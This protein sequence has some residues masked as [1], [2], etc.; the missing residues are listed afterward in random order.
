MNS[1]CF[2]KFDHS[3]NWYSASNDCLSRGGSLAVFTDIGYPS[4]NRQLAD[5]LNTTGTDKTYWIGLKRSWWMTNNEGEFDFNAFY[6]YTMITKLNIRYLACPRL[7]RP[8]PIK[9]ESLHI[10]TSPGYW[11]LQ[12]P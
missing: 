12:I 9:L 11:P 3:L 2:R 4:Y 6:F 1:K 10:Y 5:W 8:Q 7:Q